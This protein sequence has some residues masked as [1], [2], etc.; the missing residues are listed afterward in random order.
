[1]LFPYKTAA[2]IFLATSLLNRG[3]RA[4]SSGS[5]PPRTP[6]FFD[7][8]NERQRVAAR[9]RVARPETGGAAVALETSEPL[10]YL[11]A[12]LSTCGYDTDLD[13]SAPSASRSVKRSTGLWPPALPP[14]GITATP[15]APISASTQLS[16]PGLNLAQYISLS[17]SLNP[18][19]AAQSV[20]GGD[21]LP[22]DSTQVVN[23]LPLAPHL[24][25]GRQSQRHLGDASGRI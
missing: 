1:M 12:A 2:S 23:V 10:F 7:A 25:R 11:A 5:V 13:N 4:Q 15:S 6:V 9:P 8:E 20:G 21:R 17:L 19:S 24:R 22:P 14:S 18:S 3:A 16:E